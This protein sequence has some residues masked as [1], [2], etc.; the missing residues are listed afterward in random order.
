MK[1]IIKKD[2]LTRKRYLNREYSLLKFKPFL[3]N[4]RNNTN[5]SVFNKV[6]S[7]NKKLG[8]S[9]QVKNRCYQTGR[10]SS[11]DSFTKLSR[12]RFRELAH[13]GQL[14]GVKKSSW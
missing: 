2:K 1:F 14:I 3:C 13:L 9:S 12:M 11:V 8:F 7:L 4:V 5:Y 10:S 6:N